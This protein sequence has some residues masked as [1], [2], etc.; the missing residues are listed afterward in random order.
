VRLLLPSPQPPSPDISE[1][2]DIGDAELARLYAYPAGHWLRGNMVASADGASALDGVSG[3]LSTPADRRL[4]WVLRGLA[5]VILVGAGTT[6]AEHY[7]P[8]RP[9]DSW[10]P[11][12]LRDGRPATPPLAV[13]SRSLD[14]DPADP[15]FTGA[16]AD[17]TTIV[18]T[19]AA[20]P[21][22]TREALR[23]SADVVVA[24][25]AAVDL[26]QAVATLHD[27]GLGRVLCEGGPSVLAQLAAA[28]LLD[29]LCLTVSPVLAG[30]GP[31]R[32]LTGTPFPAQR[33]G[34]AAVL[35]ENGTLFCRYTSAAK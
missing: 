17:A 34:L 4:F 21:A 31:S 27:R 33:L 7:R 11:L 10:A 28:S 14:L 13:V 23:R 25:E 12:G 9:G 29:E 19:C 18:I 16:P 3:G 8:T 22:D 2:S 26:K 5:D 15:L 32:V 6:R 35:E 20:A 1:I 30:P 24:G